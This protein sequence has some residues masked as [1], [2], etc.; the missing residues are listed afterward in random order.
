MEEKVREAH[1]DTGGEPPC[2]CSSSPLLIL[3]EAAGM[4]PGPGNSGL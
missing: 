3:E 4:D 1:V 2:T